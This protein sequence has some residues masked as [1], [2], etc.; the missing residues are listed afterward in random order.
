MIDRRMRMKIGIRVDA[1]EIIATGHIMR[2]LAIAEM[3]KATGVDS[4]FIS[5]D[6]F[7]KSFINQKGYELY[8]LNS[9]W[10]YMEDEIELLQ[11]AIEK[12]EIEIL[13]V[14]SYYVTKKYFH[15]IH[16]STKIIYIDDYGKD[17][18]EIDMLIC[19]ANYYQKF[20]LE[21]RYSSNVKLLLGPKYSPLRTVFSKLP[22]KNIAPQIKELL[23][24]SGGTDHHGF[25]RDFS[26]QLWNSAIFEE[27]E[28]I[29]VICGRYYN[30]YD[31]LISEF[32]GISKFYFY[33]AVE[34]I[35]DYMLASD[36][37]ISSAG[38]VSYE[39]CAA[40]T[41]TI[42]YVI[43]DNQMEN[44]RSFYEEGLMEYAGDLRFDLVS[45]KIIE[46]LKEERLKIEY[47]ERTSS[48]M[49]RKIDGKGAQRI[50]HEI[51]HML[52]K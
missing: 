9:S 25:L 5:A 44:A 2:C 6:N 10:M 33:N 37:A 4:L 21:N 45:E 28:K 15:K 16:K 24:L 40:G 50:A 11:Q 19:Y 18:F 52:Y 23:I 3:L 13:L 36:V 42:L 39:L 8:S 31:K 29:H 34:N 22:A 26:K 17:V 49:R 20:E 12:Y 51:C 7:A 43:A 46:I 32:S 14:D 30:E 27:L 47:R 41:P 48:I 35:E 38:V 1:N